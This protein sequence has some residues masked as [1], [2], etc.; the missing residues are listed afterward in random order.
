MNAD[1]IVRALRDCGKGKTACSECPYYIENDADECRLAAMH[2]AANEINHLKAEIFGQADLIE[3]LQAQLA[4]ITAKP[5][6][7]SPVR[8][9]TDGKPYVQIGGLE[10]RDH[11]VADACARLDRYE[12]HII[13][14][15]QT[16]LSASQRRE[17]A[18]VNE[19]ED[20]TKAMMQQSTLEQAL[21][22]QPVLNRIYTIRK[23]GPQEP[24]EEI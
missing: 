10:L 13:P 7:T 24:G 1:E 16:Q 17:R 9:Y 4:E 15:L 8:Y 23:R 14:H 18:A 12:K 22:L 19:I 21:I 3:S 2:D 11:P 6:L 20:F 5:E